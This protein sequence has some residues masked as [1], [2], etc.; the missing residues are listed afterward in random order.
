MLL[1]SRWV[2]VFAFFFFFFL[3]FSF[4]W[5]RH[6]WLLSSHCRVVIHPPLG[7]HKCQLPSATP[8]HSSC[9]SPWLPPGP[10][11]ERKESTGCHSAGPALRASH[12]VHPGRQRPARVGR[13]QPG[14]PSHGAPVP[15]PVQEGRHAMEALAGVREGRWHTGA[16]PHHRRSE[17]AGVSAREPQVT[18]TSPAAL[19]LCSLVLSPRPSSVL[20]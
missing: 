18:S 17:V 9:G 12:T 6:A 1:L 16:K 8:E 14:R 10:G 19:A 20:F 15:H 4:F 13:D 3:P 5:F 7:W 11:Q 2:F